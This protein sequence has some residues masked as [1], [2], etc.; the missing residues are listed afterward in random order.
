MEIP[1]RLLCLVLGLVASPGLGAAQ[2]PIGIGLVVPGEG[3]LTE[4]GRAVRAGAEAAI[5]RANAEGGFEGRPFE[6]RVVT[7]EGLWGQ[8]LAKVVSLSFEDPVRAVIGGLDGRSAH[9]IQ[10]VITKARIP[11]VTPWASDFTLSRAMVPWFFQAVPDDRQQARAI[12]ADATARS[13]E[14][15]LVI[16]DTT[17]DS[18]HFAT[19]IRQAAGGPVRVLHPDQLL[20]LA[21][22]RI[23]E[24]LRPTAGLD[25]PTPDIDRATGPGRA[26]RGVVLAVEPGTAPRLLERLRELPSPPRAYA[27]IRLAV[28][29][30]MDTGYPGPLLFP[31]PATPPLG[32]DGPALRSL[33]AALAGDAVRTVVA[34]VRAA[35]L[36]HW[37][38]RDALA[39]Q[40]VD[41]ATGAVA[42]EASGRRAGRL[43]LL[44]S[45]GHV[46]RER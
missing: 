20:A 2:Q 35:G 3:S 25:S 39:G 34:A 46:S 27:P 5:R 9:L 32:P 37:R 36:D 13:G 43:R 42:F 18:R 23:L 31:V 8:G 29:A 40:S 28:P 44:S 6:L 45:A 38:I 22:E 16:A 33:P 12:L 19:A 7:E 10:Q 26:S 14:R 15:I 1:S 4:V 17:Y 30:V 11:F 41:G 24:L 21:P